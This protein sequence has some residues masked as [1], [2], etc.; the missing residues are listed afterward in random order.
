M[1]ETDDPPLH[2]QLSDDELLAQL[3]VHRRE[4][5]EWAAALVEVQRRADRL[6]SDERF[7]AALELADDPAPRHDPPAAT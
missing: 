2:A 7:R 6:H 4:T 5:T 1:S 3:H